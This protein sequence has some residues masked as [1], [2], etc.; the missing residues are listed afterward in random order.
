MV[1]CVVGS[2]FCSIVINIARCNVGERFGL[3]VFESTLADFS[4]VEKGIACFDESVGSC[5]IFAR[6]VVDVGVGLF[7]AFRIDFRADLSDD[8]AVV[9]GNG[10]YV[11]GRVDTLNCRELVHVHEFGKKHIFH[12]DFHCG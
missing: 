1:V 10:V 4:F 2:V 7:V 11:K 3:L 9:F 12:H 5:D 6:F 8:E